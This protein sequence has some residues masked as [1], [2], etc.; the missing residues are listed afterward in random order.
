MLSNTEVSLLLDIS[1]FNAYQHIEN[2]DKF[3]IRLA[4]SK[5]VDQAAH[6]FADTCQSYGLKVFF[7]EFKAE[8]FEPVETTLSII[9]PVQRH[10]ECQPMMFSPSSAK[11]GICADLV[12]VGTG[13]QSDYLDK[14]VRDKIVVILRDPNTPTDS[15]YKEVCIASKHGASG[16]IMANYQPW[17]FHATLESGYFSPE[18]RILPIE[19]NPIP[20]VCI[21]SADGNYLK[22]LSESN[23]V[24]VR[25]DVQ[26]IVEKRQNHNVRCLLCGTTFPEER[27]VISA[28]LDT[29]GNR[30]AND[31]GSGLAIAL[32]LAR[33][34]S[35]Y[36]CKRSI[37]FLATGCEEVASI[38]S[39]EYCKRH[40]A[41]LKNIIALFNIDMVGVGSDLHLITEGKWPEKRIATPEW[42]YLFV[43]NMA[44]ELNYKTTLGVCD[45]G[46]SDEGRFL[47]AGVPAL[48]LWK[49]SDERY[50]SALDVPE[51]VDPNALKVV[52]EI[53]GLSTWR[54]ANR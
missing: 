50:H 43:E 15:F 47:D 14:D 19:P 54:L 48:F 21:S 8:C 9:E 53:V 49:P 2:I 18:K 29:E 22:Q 34:L 51:N 31:N 13:Q 28:H 36:P 46:T 6:Y 44:R 26:A 3:G 1:A 25:L 30:G 16:I 10:V 24:K 11:G 52:A 4:G 5:A 37:E 38:G 23:N 32:E 33:V 12:F 20:A 7:E 41:S 39:W 42:L 45:L 35:E 40:S 27:V 17:P